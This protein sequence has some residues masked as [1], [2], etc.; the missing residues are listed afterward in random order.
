MRH[1]A[2]ETPP[3]PSGNPTV[4]LPWAGALSAPSQ[5]SGS[6]LQMSHFWYLLPESQGKSVPTETRIQGL[7]GLQQ[8]AAES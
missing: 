2:L 3:R 5:E 4:A 1:Q 7:F 6:T 8:R